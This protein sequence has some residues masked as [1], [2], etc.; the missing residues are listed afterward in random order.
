MGMTLASWTG[1]S[2]EQHDDFMSI[3]VLIHRESMFCNIVAC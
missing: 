3:C 2:S 1:W